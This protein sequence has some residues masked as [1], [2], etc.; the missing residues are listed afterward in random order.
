MKVNIFLVSF[1]TFLKTFAVSVAVYLLLM[2]FCH[3]I[4]DIWD[5]GENIFLYIFLGILFYGFITTVYTFSI[6][7]PMYFIDR[8]NIAELSES[9]LFSRLAPV[10][11]GISVLFCGLIAL[12]AGDGGIREGFVQ[13]NLFNIFVMSMIGLLIFIYQIKSEIK[14]SSDKK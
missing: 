5:R 10:I 11:T 12:I 13:S 4:L 8:K 9:A 7:L 1:I 3:D 2:L 6:L 14:S